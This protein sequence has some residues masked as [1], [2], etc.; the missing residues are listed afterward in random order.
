MACVLVATSKTWLSAKLWD[1]EAHFCRWFIKLWIP[2]RSGII[3]VPGLC[4]NASQMDNLPHA[5]T[6]EACGSGE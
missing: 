3:T 6:P 2:V 1:S 5:E 4:L